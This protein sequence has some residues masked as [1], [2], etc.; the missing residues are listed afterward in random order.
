MFCCG[1]PCALKEHLE[2]R[3]TFD[4][5]KLGNSPSV[6]GLMP[7]L[8]DV[9]TDCK[10]PI[11]GLFPEGWGS[12]VQGTPHGKTL[13]SKGNSSKNGGFDCWESHAWS[14]LNLAGNIIYRNQKKKIMGN[15]LYIEVYNIYVNAGFSRHV[16]FPYGSTTHESSC[17]VALRSLQSSTKRWSAMKFNGAMRWLCNGVH[18]NNSVQFFSEKN[19]WILW[20]MVDII[21]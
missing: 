2:K 9:L 20:F 4:I 18:V 16:F 12:P 7:G 17:R 21:T 13:D 19:G 10:A 8:T 15:N 11:G 14:F 3:H 1:K 5:P 6:Q